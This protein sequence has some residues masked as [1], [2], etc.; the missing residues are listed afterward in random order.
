M[1]NSNQRIFDNM[2]FDTMCTANFEITILNSIC[3]FSYCCDC[4]GFN[5]FQKTVFT[6][7]MIHTSEREH[8]PAN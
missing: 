1:N 3:I 7:L 4:C 5:Y 2:N 6:S 8:V